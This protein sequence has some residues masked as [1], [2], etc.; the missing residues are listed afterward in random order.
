MKEAAIHVAG[1]GKQYRLGKPPLGGLK[2]LL[3]RL[4]P[5]AAAAARENASFWALKDLDFTIQPGEI[6]GI[7]GRNGAGKSTLLKIL[8]RITPPTTGRAEINGRV[9]SLLEVGTG[10]HPELSG[11]DNIYLNGAIL[12]MRREEITS[13]FDEI[14][15]FAEVE[16]FIDTPVKHYSSGMYVRLAFAVAAHL[17]PEILVID[18]VLAVGDA[19]FQEKCLGK[20]DSIARTTGRTI[21]FVSHNTAAIRSLCRRALLINS[22]RLAFDGPVEEALSRYLDL[23]TRNDTLALSRL[24]PEK[25][26]LVRC[27]GLT[28]Q[29]NPLCQQAL[30]DCKTP[31]QISLDFE[32]LQPLRASIELRISDRHNTRLALSS[33][34]FETN[35]QDLHLLQPGKHRLSAT[36]R[37]PD[38]LRGTYF[39]DVILVQ[40]Y[41]CYYATIQQAFELHIE[42]SGHTWE[43]LYESSGVN[44]GHML[45]PS[46]V[47]TQPLSEP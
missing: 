22:G 44:M 43:K 17:E 34:G 39:L 25:E 1:L 3:R 36:I 18:E 47:T 42:G 29:G 16:R 24:V 4:S 33:P 21:L 5:K 15:A 35:A 14:V 6:V 10:F 46:T 45:L 40:P 41:I 11:R 31:L 2:G 9:A 27:T 30:T 19:A 12:G 32:A 26:P 38:L 13:K 7:I 20:M 23:G 37:L 8:S 28:L